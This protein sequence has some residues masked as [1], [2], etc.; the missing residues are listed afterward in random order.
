MTWSCFL[1]ACWRGKLYEGL[2]LFDISRNLEVAEVD[3]DVCVC[4]WNKEKLTALHSCNSVSWIWIKC[5]FLLKCYSLFIVLYRNLRSILMGNLVDASGMSIKKKKKITFAS[6]VCS[7]FL[8]DDVLFLI[9]MLWI[10]LH[11]NVPL[12]ACIFLFQAC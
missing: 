6:C 10:G 7:C 9:E 12:W 3:K 5:Y 2:H 4:V 1:S 8:N 11:K